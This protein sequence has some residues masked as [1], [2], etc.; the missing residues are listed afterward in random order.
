[1][2]SNKNNKRSNRSDDD[3]S[4]SDFVLDSSVESSESDEEMDF[5][6]SS[7]SSSNQQITLKKKQNKTMS[8]K[9]KKMKTKKSLSTS[10]SSSSPMSSKSRSVS[11]MSSIGSEDSEKEAERNLKSGHLPISWSGCIVPH[12]SSNSTPLIL[13]NAKF[14]GILECVSVDPTGKDVIVYPNTH[15]E[16]LKAFPEL[17][18]LFI[19]RANSVPHL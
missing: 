9:N 5:N 1:M 15:I 18:D 17:F 2:S 6:E 4:D 14:G 7:P 13:R 8:N 19:K 11:P 16:R 10:S 3:D 12:E